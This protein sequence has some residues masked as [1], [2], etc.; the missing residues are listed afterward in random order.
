MK[1]RSTKRGFT[2][3]ELLV[4]LSII[5]IM[6]AI[7]APSLNR[8]R[9]A[10]KRMICAN[11]L[12]EI[13]RGLSFYADAY[14]NKMPFYGGKDPTFDDPFKC[15]ENFREAEACPRDD[16]RIHFAFHAIPQWC[17]GGDL[18]KSYPMK[19]GCLYRA[20]IMI[21]ARIF[22]CPANSSPFY[23][24]ESYINPPPW[25]SLPQKF[26]T[27]VPC[28]QR[29]RIGYTYFPVDS[30]M[31]RFYDGLMEAPMATARRYD[32]VDPRISLLADVLWL[33]EELSHKTKDSFAVNAAFKDTHVVYCNDQK[34]F[35]Y[36]PVAD[37]L[38][39]W[40]LWDPRKIQFNYFY[41]NFLKKIQP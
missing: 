32:K 19:L 33:R 13:A 28:G 15:T 18:D 2:L 14:G 17:E 37:P 41:Y 30:S 1:S 40:Y 34:M 35:S 4:V 39:L 27:E 3:I 11:R 26:N 22:Y 10:S 5:S 9:G 25:G 38:R 36:D 7:I 31:H 21:D 8:C 29:V 16:A 23:Q 6:L 12:K 24:Y 20:G